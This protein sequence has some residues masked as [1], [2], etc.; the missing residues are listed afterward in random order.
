MALLA[1]KIKSMGAFKA[2]IGL[3]VLKLVSWFDKKI[4]LFLSTNLYPLADVHAQSPTREEA[5]V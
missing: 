4:N 5:R 3:R 2:A 1:K